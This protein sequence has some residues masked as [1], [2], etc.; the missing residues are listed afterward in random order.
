[1]KIISNILPFLILMISVYSCQRE[2]EI[3]LPNAE[4]LVV[5]EG[6]IEVGKSPIIFLTRNRGFF[7]EFPTDLSTL[8][9]EF[10]IQDALVTV[11]DGVQTEILEFTINLNAYPFVYY[12]GTLIKGE[13]GKSY[14]LSIQANGKNLSATTFIAPP[15]EIDSSWFE[16]NPFDVNEDSLGVSYSS[17]ADP[18]TFGNSYRIFA[19][20]NSEFAFYPVSGGAFSDEFVNGQKITFF[21]GQG[22]KPFESSGDFVPKEFFY[23][24]GDTVYLKFASIGRKEY[25]FYATLDQAINSNGNPFA[26]PTLVKSN[27][28]GGLGVWCGFSVSYDTLIATN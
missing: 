17:I 25:D 24:L 5:V 26:A 14:S 12:T 2:I 9:A 4:D 19:K 18:D 27:V 13:I 3:E 10:V 6:R 23:I 22:E 16:L 28:E 8:I 7:K 21:Y 15:I 1:M 20:R 11:S